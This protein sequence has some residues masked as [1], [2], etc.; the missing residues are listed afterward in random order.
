MTVP[1]VVWQRG[2]RVVVAA[3]VQRV[4]VQQVVEHGVVQPRVGVVVVVVVAVERQAAADTA[5]VRAVRPYIDDLSYAVRCR[6]AVVLPQ[7]AV[8]ATYVR[9]A[10]Q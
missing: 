4:A 5:S 9:A 2:P 3:A 1:A 10:P 7:A 6:A 8:A